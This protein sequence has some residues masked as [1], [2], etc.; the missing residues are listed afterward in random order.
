MLWD[1]DPNKFM[2]YDHPCKKNMKI[3]SGI[4]FPCTTKI[5]FFW[6][7]YGPCVSGEAGSW[8]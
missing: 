2:A 6:L 1:R 3:G 4:L 8:S 5:Q 7:T